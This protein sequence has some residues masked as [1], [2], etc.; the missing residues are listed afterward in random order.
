MMMVMNDDD[1][2]EGND[3][4]A[5]PPIQCFSRV[6]SQLIVTLYKILAMLPVAFSDKHRRNN[7]QQRMGK[8]PYHNDCH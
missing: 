3:D 5:S 4:F 8:G 7:V 1:D 2:A 6:K